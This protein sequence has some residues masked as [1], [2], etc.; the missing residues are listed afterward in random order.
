[1]SF[2]A[3]STGRGRAAG[4]PGGVLTAWLGAWLSGR[5]GSDD[6]L[7]AVQR[8]GVP[9][10]VDG[11][12]TEESGVPLARLLTYVRA[13]APASV[14]LRLPVPGDP[15]GLPPAVLP[16]AASAGEAVVVEPLA[17]EEPA[18]VLV[19]QPDVRG[20]ELEPLV[21]VR[22]Q[23]LVLAGRAADGPAAPTRLREAELRLD[24]A[25]SSAI[26]VLLDLG[27]LDRLSPEA[28]DAI[29]SLRSRRGPGPALPPG[30][31]PD[32][33]RVLV[34]AERLAAV[35]ALTTGADP[36]SAAGDARRAAALREVATAI[37]WTRRLAYTACASGTAR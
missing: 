23:Y 25:L 3:V 34:T 17:R 12:P 37:R 33:V 10:V 2:P 11:L 29:A 22:W 32:A 35:L 31:P 26:G 27:Q 19:P 16:P 14:E 28:R 13:C 1:M 36:L 15:D 8:G 20:S 6:L 21:T 30:S 18:V 24:D 5:T 9:H 7:A 4:S